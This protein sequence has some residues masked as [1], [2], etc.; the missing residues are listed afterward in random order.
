VR[1]P[2]QSTTPSPRGTLQRWL[3]RMQ[4]GVVILKFVY[5][6]YR[7]VFSFYVPYLHHE[8]STHKKN[9]IKRVNLTNDTKIKESASYWSFCL[10]VHLNNNNN[11][12]SRDKD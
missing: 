9:I 8:K 12:I 6:E 10:L 4:H 5:K 3:C 7:E 2:F 1:R 11:N